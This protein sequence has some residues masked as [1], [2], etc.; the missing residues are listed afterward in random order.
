MKPLMPKEKLLRIL[1]KHKRIELDISH[2]GF[3]TI[4]R[5]RKLSMRKRI[6][7]KV[8]NSDWSISCYEWRI[9]GEKHPI[10]IERSI[11]RMY[12]YD[13]GRLRIM[14]VRKGK[15]VLWSRDK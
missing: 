12:K 3:S 8:N 11:A 1:K 4:G 5:V 9:T 14:R 6:E 15:K 10:N 13:R 7:W 2:K